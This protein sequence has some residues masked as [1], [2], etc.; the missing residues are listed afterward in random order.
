MDAKDNVGPTGDVRVGRCLERTQAVS[1]DEDADAEAGEGAVQDGR[2]GE[3]GAKPVQEE[4]PD[5][6][7]SVAV[8]PQDP[9]GVPKRSQ[10]VSADGS[11][12]VSGERS[13]KPTLALGAKSV[14]EE[15]DGGKWA[16]APKVG[17][18]EA[19]AASLADVQSVLEVLVQG[20]E[21]AVG[22]APEEEEDC[23]EADRIERF[24]EGQLG[25]LCPL[26]VRGAQG[27]ALP[28]GFGKHLDWSRGFGPSHRHTTDTAGLASKKGGLA[29]VASLWARWNQC[30]NEGRGE[31][32]ST[33][34]RAVDGQRRK[35]SQFASAWLVGQ[36]RGS[37]WI[38]RYG[39]G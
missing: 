28:E 19:G 13:R 11:G 12:N 20:V 15:E 7:S 24:L 4:A 38:I 27:A 16:H 8:V 9:G 10:G 37:S 30:S 21:E 29:V 6:D 34:D 14:G 35:R 5:E 31:A 2:D 1:D 39:D 36:D 23:D 17:G 25:G 26:L 3:Q 22:E 33:E 32:V 18:L